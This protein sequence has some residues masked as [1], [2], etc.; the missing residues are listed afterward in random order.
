MENGTWEVVQLPDGQK[1]IEF[2]WVYKKKYNAHGT[3]E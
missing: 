3:L 2:K 1:A